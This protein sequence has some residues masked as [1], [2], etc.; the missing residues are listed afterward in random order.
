ML[1]LRRLFRSQNGFTLIELVFVVIIL[2]ILAGIALM[3]MGTT[4][5]RDKNAK[6]QVDFLSIATAIK[7]YKVETSNFPSNLA[8]LITTSGTYEPMLDE[9]P[10]DPWGTD[11]VYL[12]YTDYVIISSAN[13][14]NRTVR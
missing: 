10:T 4:E 11:Y 14:E 5:T 7:V 13:G 6:V 3:N 2:S 12:T 1:K 8:Q 9:V